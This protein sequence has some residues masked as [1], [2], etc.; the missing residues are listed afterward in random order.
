MFGV[1]SN[2]NSL[3]SEQTEKSKQLLDII[4]NVCDF[5]CQ[6]ENVITLVQAITG[7]DL[8]SFYKESNSF[9]AIDLAAFKLK[10]DSVNRNET[11]K[12]NYFG[13]I[14]S[15]DNDN[16]LIIIHNAVDEVRL[17]YYS[18]MGCPSL[19]EIVQFVD[20]SY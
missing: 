11:W 6:K 10:Q 8:K 20:N 16:G 12:K 15:V 18:E 9:K 19:D 1:D 7:E 17:P 13:I 5:G 2:G 14:S 3:I 4:T